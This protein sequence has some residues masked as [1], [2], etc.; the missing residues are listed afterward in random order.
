MTATVYDVGPVH[1]ATGA[2][3]ARYF[4]AT[5]PFPLESAEQNKLHEFYAHLSEGRLV[6]TSCA[7]C[8]RNDWPPRG[9]CPD[10]TSDEF[11][12]VELPREGTVHGFT[13]QETG[14]PPSFQ[15]PRV[16]AVVKVGA[17]RI[18]API[19]G[20]RASTVSAGAWVRLSPVQVAADASGNPRWLVAF[21]PIDAPT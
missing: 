15:T 10:C 16:F 19:V 1:A 6:T 14:V 18:F 21:E 20:P 11:T 17:A 3:V 9:F 5:D 12:W 8:G 4:R 7:G 2:S 13:I